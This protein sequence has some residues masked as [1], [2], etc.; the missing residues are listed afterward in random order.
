MEP[1]RR[2]LRHL[3][4]LG[5]EKRELSPELDVDLSLALLL[6]PI[7]YWYIFLRRTSENPQI[8]A[9]GVVNAFWAAYG[10]QQAPSVVP[11]R[12]ARV[13]RRRVRQGL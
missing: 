8:L 2:E 9:E 1:P 3:L 4:R 11:P 7:L 13:G 6:G 5:I 10:L 12:S